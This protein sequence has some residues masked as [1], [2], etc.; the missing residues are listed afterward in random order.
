ML[1]LR[2]VFSSLSGNSIISIDT[3]TKVKLAGGSKNP[4]QGRVTKRVKGSNVQVFGNSGY[5]SMVNRRLSKEGKEPDF[6]SQPR[7]WGTRVAGLP[8]VEN[9][10]QDYL[11]A[12]FIKA[13]EVEYLVDG[14]VVDK[15]GIVGII[16]S[17][18]DVKSQNGLEN[19]VIVRTFKAE[20]I[21]EIRA[22]GKVFK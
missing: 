5:S 2:T 19:K 3:E 14:K 10:S 12:I 11:E 17:G 21:K 16:N 7:T 9:D 8:I 1:N 4:L 22:F 15:S 18:D 6:V 20:S 13:G